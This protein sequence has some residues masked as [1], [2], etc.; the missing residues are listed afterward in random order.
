MGWRRRSRRRR[1]LVGPPTLLSGF[2]SQVAHRPHRI[3]VGRARSHIGVRV[4]RTVSAIQPGIPLRLASRSVLNTAEHVISRNRTMAVVSRR[5]PVQADPGVS[6]CCYLQIG[7]WV[8]L[9]ALRWL[10]WLRWLGWLRWLRWLGWLGWQLRSRRRRDLVGPHTLL[11]GF[12]PQVAHRIHRISVGRPCSHTGVRV[13][14]TTGAVQPDIPSRFTGRR[15]LHTSVYVVRSDCPMT[16]ASRRRPAQANPRFTGSRY[17]QTG[18]RPRI[19]R[20][21]DGRLQCR[22]KQYKQQE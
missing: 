1:D 3:T 18:G 10:R 16:V 4:C 19:R 20:L 12:S 14:R 15:T 6:G 11:S 21:C 17:S 2:S 8:W 13:C 22:E 7:R 9:W 5:R